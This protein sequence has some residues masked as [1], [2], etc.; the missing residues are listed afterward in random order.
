MIKEEQYILSN[1]NNTPPTSGV[2]GKKKKK[3]KD[4]AQYSKNE[5]P[6]PEVSEPVMTFAPSMHK[7]INGGQASAPGRLTV[8]EFFNELLTRL[9]EG[10]ERAKS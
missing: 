1:I 6:M 4:M 10:Y 2:F 3:Q 5:T 8:D 7:L 9:H